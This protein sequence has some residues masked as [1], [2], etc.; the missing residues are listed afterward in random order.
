MAIIKMIKG[1]PK[2][3][4]NLKKL[5][6]YITQPAKTRPDLVGGCN[7]DW[8]RSY[9]DFM[10]IKAEFDQED[11]IQ[12]KHMVMSFDIKDDVTVELAKQIADELLQHK[13][14]DGF[15]V[16]YAV[17]KDKEH[18]HTHFLI[19]SV[20]M[21]TGK[22]WHQTAVD[23][24][25]LKIK[26]NEVCRKYHL[27][28][29]KLNQDKGYKTNA[30]SQNRFESWKYELYLAAVNAARRSLSRED[31]KNLMDKI[32]YGVSWEDDKKYITFTTPGGKKCRNRKMYPR[33]KFTKEALQR[34][35]DYNL[36][37]YNAKRIEQIQQSFVKKVKEQP[38]VKYPFSALVAEEEKAESLDYEQWYG[39][40]REYLIDDDKYD[41]YKCIGYAMKY[42]V[43]RKDFV[44]RLNKMGLDA[45]FDEEANIS[46]FISKQGIEY[47]NY[48]LYQGEQYSPKALAQRFAECKEKK[49][50]NSAF[51]KCIKASKNLKDFRDR[52]FQK[53]YGYIYK[54]GKYQFFDVA[55]KGIDTGDLDDRIDKIFFE[56]MYRYLNRL[57]WKAKD[58]NKFFK[59]L[60]KEGNNIEI[61][62]NTIK[63]HID[64]QIFQDKDFGVDAVKEYFN[65]KNEVKELRSII[66]RV[67]MYS[68][69]KDDFIRLMKECGY[70]VNWYDAQL[71]TDAPTSNTELALCKAEGRIEFVTPTGSLLSNTDLNPAQWFSV[72]ALKEQ[73][74]KNVCRYL[75]NLKW[76]VQDIDE[77]F[78][79]LHEEGNNAEV[80]G[81]T[82]KYHVSGR[83][84]QDKE[85]DINAMNEYFE[86]EKDKREL[87][88]V[89]GQVKMC[90]LSKESF[91][92]KM[93][94]LGYTVEWHDAQPKPNL[95]IPSTAL[96]LPGAAGRI[97]FTTPQGNVFDNT[98]IEPVGWFS[99]DALEKQFSQNKIDNTFG[100]LF[101]FL[102]IFNSNDPTPVSSAM[103]LVH[104]NELT[105]EKLREFMYHFEKGTASLYNKN[106]DH[107]F[108]M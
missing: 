28:E 35:F 89:I 91:I 58:P 79:L 40:N 34:H 72:D 57:R 46:I 78:E 88:H 92:S 73:F 87:R 25:N 96:A 106:L 74:D 15:Q 2:T 33:D 100:T 103:S 70:K 80:E 18:I 6:N 7:C 5:I 8:S 23:L 31:F 49:E 94:Q 37:Q 98:E 83:T 52:L 3:K 51:W 75:N 44:V 76:K 20:N 29:I 1:S 67:K 64:G 47:G 12:G 77:F 10:E 14:F 82:I 16:L 68:L 62:G 11:G 86:L 48:E 4:T 26:S 66:G 54:S 105:G 9:H 27:S 99:V 13:I 61:D 84:F 65:L 90:A 101:D 24:Q 42:A 36:K 85:F 60:H 81:D 63:Y 22:R 97:T 107:D 41:T 45:E 50:F 108:S 55:G 43:D 19:N 102:R 32:G 17:H 95:G 104:S 38:D 53:G 69:S 59:L 93:Q 21:K 30:E 71:K 39:K 56:K